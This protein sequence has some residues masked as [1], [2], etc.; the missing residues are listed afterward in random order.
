M[1]K[2][3]NKDKPMTT[4]KSNLETL[5]EELNARGFDYTNTAIGEIVD[6]VDDLTAFEFEEL[7][8]LWSESG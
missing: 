1:A 3:K 7:M 2:K 4:G 5:R 8:K 6:L